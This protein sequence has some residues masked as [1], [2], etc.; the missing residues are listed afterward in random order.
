MKKS[1]DW[2]NNMVEKKYSPKYI[3]KIVAMLEKHEKEMNKGVLR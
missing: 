3:K 2:V 1:L